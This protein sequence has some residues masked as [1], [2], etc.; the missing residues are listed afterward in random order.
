LEWAMW[1]KNIS[2][3]ISQLIAVSAAFFT[4]L[5]MTDTGYNLTV[6]QARI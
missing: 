6:S 5:A 1:V 2:I 4:F 3:A